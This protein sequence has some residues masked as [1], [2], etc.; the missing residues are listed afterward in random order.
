VCFLPVFSSFRIRVLYLSTFQFLSASP[1][2]IDNTRW[3]TV[4]L[5]LWFSCPRFSRVYHASKCRYCQ[6]GG[7]CSR[8]STPYF[9]WDPG[10]F[11][12]LTGSVT[13]DKV[14]SYCWIFNIGNKKGKQQV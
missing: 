8:N 5:S 9:W 2:M 1:Q 6:N 7:D 13:D 10:S 12:V 4:Y 14:S 11:F 3:I